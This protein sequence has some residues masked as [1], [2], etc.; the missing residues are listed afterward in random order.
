MVC[1]KSQVCE[2]LGMNY[3]DTSLGY[4]YCCDIKDFY[5]IAKDELGLDDEFKSMRNYKEMR[6]VTFDKDPRIIK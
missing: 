3:R 2:K 5:A 4:L 1:K 6:L